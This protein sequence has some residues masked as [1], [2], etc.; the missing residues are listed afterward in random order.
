MVAEACCRVSGEGQRVVAEGQRVE[1][2]RVVA[3]RLRVSSAVAMGDPHLLQ[4]A[5]AP[6]RSFS[7]M[8][9][10]C[11]PAR[12]ETQRR[13]SPLSLAYLPGEGCHWTSSSTTA[14]SVALREL[15]QPLLQPLLQLH[16]PFPEPAALMDLLS[17]AL[18]WQ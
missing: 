10:R 18:P 2:Q 3:A 7:E 4:I 12:R 15:V 8:G 6:A 17:Q 5:S 1:G 9:L 11:S 16:S 14:E 13:S